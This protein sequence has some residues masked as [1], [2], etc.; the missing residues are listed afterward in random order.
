MGMKYAENRTKRGL[1][2]ARQ[3]VF[4]KKAFS[5]FLPFFLLFVCGNAWSWPGP[6]L[7]QIAQKFTAVDAKADCMRDL[8]LAFKSGTEAESL[9]FAPQYI[10][11]R[12]WEVLKRCTPTTWVSPAN[13]LTYLAFEL[14]VHN[15]IK[16]DPDHVFPSEDY[17]PYGSVAFLYVYSPSTLNRGKSVS[18][19]SCDVSCLG[20]P[21][22]FAEG[23]KVEEAVDFSSEHDGRF[24]WVRFY[25]SSP[26]MEGTRFGDKWRHSFSRSLVF[27]NLPGPTAILYRDDGKIIAFKQQGGTWIPDS[28][29]SLGLALRSDAPGWV[30]SDYLNHIDER[31]DAD[32]NLEKIEYADGYFIGLQYLSV[33][34]KRLVGISDRS[35][36]SIS[37]AYNSL[38]FFSSVLMPDGQQVSYAYQGLNQHP[39]L[40]NQVLSEV[41]NLDGTQKRY[42]YLADKI[43]ILEAVID[44]QAVEYARFTYNDYYD[45]A[46]G[47]VHAGGADAY[48]GVISNQV[49]PTTAEIVN[50]NGLSA[51]YEYALFNGINRTTKV[52]RNCPGACTEISTFTYDANGRA[53]KTT[54]FSGKVT[55]RDFDAQG[56]LVRIIEATGTTS[57]RKSETDWDLTFH[58]PTQ[59]RI[60]NTASAQ[61]RKHDWTYND[62]GQPLSE[63]TTDPL[64]GASRSVATTYCEQADVT[65][66]ACAFVG[67]VKT[68]DGARTD[69]TDVT[70][71]FYRMVDEAGCSAAPTTCQYRKGDLWKITNTLGHTKE[72]V[73][74]D[75]AGRPL[76]VK[77]VNN[78]LTD[79]EYSPRGWLTAQKVRGNNDASE[80][81]DRVTRLEYWPTGLVKKIT[82]P[83]G[84]FTAYVYDAAHRLTGISDNA[85]NS[86]IY[87]LNAAGERTSEDTKDASG[88][89]QRTLSRTYNTLGQLQAQTDAYNRIT[90]FT[91]DLNSNLDATTDAL[92]RVADNNYDPLNR[93][94]RTLQDMN[95]IAAETKFSYDAL[96]NLTQVNDPKGLNTTYTYNGFSDLTQLV[97]PDTG[98]TLYTYDSA[99]NRKTQKDARN[100]TTTYSYDALNRLTSVTY[101][102]TALNT[103]YTY[104][105]A[106]TACVAGETFTVGRLT[107]ITDQSGNTV[108]CYDRF[109]NLVRKVQTTNAKVFTLRYTWNV[110]GQLTSVIYP[111][112]AV[113]DYLYDAQGRVLEV[114]AKTATGT[115]Q[116]LLTNASYYPFG[117]VAQWSYGNGRL[118]KRSLNQN[119]Q[120]G[121]V[122]VT[123]PGG[124]S[125]G[126]EFD[127]VGN[128]KTLRNAN[129]A[130]P[131]R[132]VFGYDALNR[133]TESK[134]GITNALLEGYSYDKTGNRTSATVGA[135]TTP[136]AYLTGN[137]R[138]NIVGTAAARVYDAN[139]NSTSIPG[140]VVKNF[141]YGDHNR[142]TQYKEG[143]TVKMNYVY[144][145][146]GEQ[147]R[148]YA[149]STTNVYSLYD[150]AG[151]WLGD[152]NNAAAATQQVIWFGDLPVGVFVGAAAAQKLHYIEA[153]A[154]G[155]PRVVVDPTRGTQGTAVWTWDLAGEAFGVTAPNQNPDGDANQFVFNMRFPGQRYDAASGLHYNMMRDYEPATGRYT[156]SDPMGLLLQHLLMSYKLATSSRS[157]LL[158]ADSIGVST[159]SYVSAKPLTSIDPLGLYDNPAGGGNNGGGWENHPGGCPLIFGFTIFTVPNPILSLPQIHVKFCVYSC[160]PPGTCPAPG[161]EFVKY[162]VVWNPPYECPSKA[163][164]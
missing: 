126:Y 145:G 158:I 10:I 78:V 13:G 161:S 93:L 50:P 35:G 15:Y 98:T 121:F 159:Y 73:R 76:S 42:Q 65:A 21:V 45:R 44:E 8:A 134:D 81:D 114:G 41:A 87:T 7:V 108:Y 66:G 149:S 18:R 147:V 23:N 163:R 96:D 6:P 63:V 86:I 105:T 117:P 77:D 133:I 56:H 3:K 118:M 144:N 113:A 38:G 85:G 68:V 53:D 34:E 140:T 150:E 55:D 123:T 26:L 59:R 19:D 160:A 162:F 71:Y 155:T 39:L 102:A 151:H 82:Q 94:S 12:K 111:D 83:D 29:V 101:A 135:T 125:I 36:R 22:L 72:I 46:I 33:P 119:Y 51:R 37:I 27:T 31:Y 11:E 131:T 48:S 20:N 84:A 47:T 142:M 1:L 28:D 14:R 141:V 49:T 75:G 109:G 164:K 129:Q 64:T 61:V 25:N 136:Y 40:R 43:A 54:D 103:T 62:R 79:F 92:T 143:T 148:K 69:A 120:P 16:Y 112:G 30:V 4:S 95:G 88:A 52:T 154:L 106:Q 70:T 107:K 146:R 115:R 127:A 17:F 153:D 57:A 132:R 80:A 137:H 116:V 122:E 67:L 74:Y 124:I 138:L 91:Y 5:F 156:Q 104:D 128:L 100:K 9:I 2:P 89:L 32:G 60:Y 97:S 24:K 58:V 90:T 99:G 157:K 110:A 139:G 152:Y 130:D